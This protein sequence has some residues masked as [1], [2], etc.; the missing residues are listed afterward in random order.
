MCVKSQTLQFVTKTDI[1]MISGYQPIII[2]L[3]T[4]WAVGLLCSDSLG[5]FLKSPPQLTF[6]IQS[7]HPGQN[8]H[9]SLSFSFF[10][11]VFLFDPETIN[12]FTSKSDQ[13]VT[14]P[15]NTQT[16]SRK[17]VMRPLKFI[18]RGR[19]CYMHLDLT[20]EGSSNYQML[21]IKGLTTYS[22]C[23]F[24]CPYSHTNKQSQ[25]K[26]LFQFEPV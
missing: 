25:K 10:L 16:L 4:F 3:Q 1:A 12:P 21:G 24:N 15:Y 8:K 13:H 5:L 19:S 23:P 14:S 9:S 6:K 22:M 2:Q 7:R 11:F 26:N 18:S 17:Q 20:P